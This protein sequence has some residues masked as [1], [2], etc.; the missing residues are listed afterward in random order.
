MR[1][2]QKG[3][4]V[5]LNAAQRATCRT[6]EDILLSRASSRPALLTGLAHQGRRRCRTVGMTSAWE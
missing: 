3:S 6:G 2:R 4:W 5:R 1:K